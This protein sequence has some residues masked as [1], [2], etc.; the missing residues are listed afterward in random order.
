MYYTKS[1]FLQ[2]IK[3]Q[4]NKDFVDGWKI[5]VRYKM[6]RG[7]V[8]Q[9]PTPCRFPAYLVDRDDVF[10]RLVGGIWRSVKNGREYWPV[11]A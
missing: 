11:A 5:A 1:E 10:V 9:H 6:A 2:G 3:Q 7:L 4:A 8:V